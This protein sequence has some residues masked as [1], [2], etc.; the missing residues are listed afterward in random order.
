MS[1]APIKAILWDVGNIFVTFND[2]KACT[3]LSKYSPYRPEEIY[4]RIFNDIYK[5]NTPVKKF[6]EKGTFSAEEFFTALIELLSLNDTLTFEE[7]SHLWSDIFENNTDIVG[8][9]EK[10]NSSI[11]MCL[12]SN[13]DP[14]H[15]K[16]IDEVPAI[17]TY[18]AP[19]EKQVKSY[20]SGVCKPDEKIYLDALTAV[21]LTKEDAGSVL[22]IEDMEK[23]R[24]AFLN[25]GGN[26]LAYDCSKDGI[27]VL[28]NGLKEYGVI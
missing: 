2:M 18:F 12:L 5:D 21:G 15:W 27:E 22:F 19:E 7:F 6:L 20:T 23:N 17:K 3:S 26:V 13:T 24:E 11:P 28:E 25:L 8:I 14:I 9:F 16:V 1:T 4:R 10:I